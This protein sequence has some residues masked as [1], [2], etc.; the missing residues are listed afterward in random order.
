MRVFRFL[1]QAHKW[2][3]IV[4]A[5]WV[6]L[7]AATGFL[8]LLKKK[9]DWIQPPT[10]RDTAGGVEDF[11][12]QQ[13]LLAVVFAQDHPDF[14]S[15]ADID[16]IDFRPDRR[17]F[18]VISRRRDSELQIGAVSGEVL[19]VATRRSDL[20]ERLHDGSFF[21][22]FVHGWL[23]PLLATGVALLAVSGVWIWLDPL[24]RRRR[25]RSGR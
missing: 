21:G 12:T 23:S 7:L 25:R 5:L 8:L 15:L 3:G 20:L 19:S 14:R 13:Q 4:L 6:L 18:K 1:W 17:V 2:V 24:L 22:G 10:R 16:R 9:V 11:I